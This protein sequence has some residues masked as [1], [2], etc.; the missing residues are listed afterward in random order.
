MALASY[1][2]DAAPSAV[3]TTSFTPVSVDGLFSLGLPESA[4]KRPFWHS[5]SR[6]PWGARR[7]GCGMLR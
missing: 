1:D 4:T 7:S 2:A 5:T 3:L 6:A